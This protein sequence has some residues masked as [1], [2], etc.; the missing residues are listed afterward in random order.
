[1]NNNNIENQKRRIIDIFRSLGVECT[2]VCHT[3]GPTTVSYE[4]M[5]QIGTRLSRL[6]KYLNDVILWLGDSVRIVMPSSN[7]ATIRVEMPSDN[8]QP[9]PFRAI[10][11]SKEFQQSD[12]ILPIA[13]GKTSMN[14]WYVMDLAK[15]RHLLIAGR[16]G[17]GKSMCLHI[18][19][20]S[21]LLKRTPEEVRFI[22]IA[23]DATELQAY[24]SIAE[25]YLVKIPDVNKMIVT[26]VCQT[27]RLLRSLCVELDNRYDCLRKLHLR[28]ISGC[29][30]FPHII[31][32]IDE[33]ANFLMNAGKQFL[34][35]LCL[36]A[37]LGHA[38]GIHL[39]ITTQR[40]TDIVPGYFPVRIAL[41]TGGVMD[42]R[43]IIGRRGAESLLRPGDMLFSHNILLRIQGAYID[44]EDKD[45]L[46]VAGKATQWE[47][48]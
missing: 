43:T 33:Y 44:A 31:V 27:I 30:S 7:R 48:K 14:E 9:I 4:L 38:V 29:N 17:F 20:R 11:N 24:S 47:I 40:V 26:D 13:F 23:Q 1:M 2:E 35:P 25:N 36:L 45:G 34:L 3:I 18:I 42:S 46:V 19:I 10:V 37:Q 12:C 22:F 6:K 41:Q 28:S 39:V 32:I 15:T 16:T 8:P 21:L 5:P